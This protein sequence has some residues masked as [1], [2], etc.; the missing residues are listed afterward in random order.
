MESLKCTP[1]CRSLSGNS[2][3]V[4]AGRPPSAR[5]RAHPCQAHHVAFQAW[6]THAA[7]VQHGVQLPNAHLWLTY[8]RAA[9]AQEVGKFQTSPPSATNCDVQ[10]HCEANLQLLEM[11]HSQLTTTGL[12][13]I[14]MASLSHAPHRTARQGCPCTA[15]GRNRPTCTCTWASPSHVAAKTGLR[16]T[17]QSCAGCSATGSIRAGQQRAPEH[18]DELQR[19][20]DILPGL[21]RQVQGRTARG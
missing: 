6:R 15:R 16:R 18:A 1:D 9:H 2:R 13:P 14:N 11:H 7:L 3:S 4:T 10:S 20:R 21:R 5:G 17:E 8:T 19:L 12:A